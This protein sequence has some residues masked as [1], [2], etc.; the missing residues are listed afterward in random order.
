VTFVLSDLSQ[1]I[2]ENLNTDLIYCGSTS[3]H[4]FDGRF[5]V[6]AA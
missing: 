4:F 5:L 3:F 6:I 1:K 2:L